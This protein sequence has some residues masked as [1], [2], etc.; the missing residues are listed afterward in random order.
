MD[1]CCS[2]R[3]HVG[4]SNLFDLQGLEKAGVGKDGLRR[5]WVT[6]NGVAWRGKALA[7]A[8]LD[9]AGALRALLELEARE[10]PRAAA[11]RLREPTVLTPAT[12]GSAASADSTPPGRGPRADR[13]GAFAI[14]SPEQL[15]PFALGGLSPTSRELLLGK[16]ADLQRLGAVIEP[17]PARRWPGIC[18][19]HRLTPGAAPAVLAIARHPARP[20]LALLG[21]E[22]QVRQTLAPLVRLPGVRVEEIPGPREATGEPPA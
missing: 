14:W 6:M 11:A 7:P 22:H 1:A 9:A 18:H 5:W 17:N 4:V 12:A 16:L 13:A 3:L 15:R 8:D 21:A 19:A 2:V 10:G 20:P